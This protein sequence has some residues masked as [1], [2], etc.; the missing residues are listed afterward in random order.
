MSA[1][2]GSIINAAWNAAQAQSIASYT[3]RISGTFGYGVVQPL[4]P[5]LR[6]RSKKRKGKHRVYLLWIDEVFQGEFPSNKVRRAYL[7]ATLVMKENSHE[8]EVER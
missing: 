5:T 4:P 3:Q 1:T 8:Q 7:E 6:F 2:A